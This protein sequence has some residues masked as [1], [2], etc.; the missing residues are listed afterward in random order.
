MFVDDT[1]FISRAS[2]LL[3]PLPAFAIPIAIALCFIFNATISLVLLLIA[4]IVAS[5][6]VCKTWKRTR[7]Q[8]TGVRQELSSLQGIVDVSRDAI[9]GVT[10]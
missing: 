1:S 3:W 5:V 6:I 10:T 4:Q 9:I 7:E 2:R 8:L